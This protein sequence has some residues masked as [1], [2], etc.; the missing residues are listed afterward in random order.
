MPVIADLNGVAKGKFQIPENV[1]AGSK[2][3]EFTGS[4]GSR[5]VATF[6]GGGT[7]E[8]VVQRRVE[9]IGVGVT[10]TYGID[11]LAQTFS[12]SQKA[13][14][15]GIDLWFA[16]KG[17]TRVVVQIRETEVGLPT[18]VVLAQAYIDTSSIVIGQYNQI[19]FPWPATLLRDTEY[20]I[21]VLCDDAISSVGTAELGKWDLNGDSWVTSQPYQIGVLLSSSNASTWTAHQDR[22]LTFRLLKRRYTQSERVVDLGATQVNDATDLIVIANAVI[23]DENTRIDYRLT[24]PDTTELVVASMQPIQLPAPI[25][26]MVKLEA[27]L[28]GSEDFSPILFPDTVLVH[29]KI[30]NEGT[31]FSRAMLAGQNVRVRVIYEALLPSGSTCEVSLSD[32]ANESWTLMP[33]ISYSPLDNGWYEFIHEIDGFTAEM[34]RTKIKIN[35]STSARPY[36]RELRIL[37]M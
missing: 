23:P 6:T 29:G 7:L 24:L 10:V 26:G 4:G 14:I 18:Q 3:V 13:Q 35:G 37:V 28:H 27:I 31:Y 20:A 21:V 36:V 16:Q 8:N 11:P 19:L 30:G 32:A 34:V 5:G 1:R 9:R 12:L 33:Q 22:D 25:T 15:A 17:S 2:S